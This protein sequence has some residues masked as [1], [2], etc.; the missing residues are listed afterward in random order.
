MFCWNIQPTQGRESI[1]MLEKVRDIFEFFDLDMDG[2]LTLNDI[3]SITPLIDINSSSKTKLLFDPPCD[4]IKFLAKIQSSPQHIANNILDKLQSYIHLKIQ[5]VFDTFSDGAMIMNKTQIKTMYQFAY[6]KESDWRTT[7][8]EQQCTV[9]SFI[10]NWSTLGI[11]EQHG[12][13]NETQRRI[14]E[15]LQRIFTFFDKNS[16]NELDEEQIK[17]ILEL[18]SIDRSDPYF[19]LFD[20]SELSFDAFLSKFTLIH[21]SLTSDVLPRLENHIKEQV[22]WLYFYIFCC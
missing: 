18:L 11:Y 21:R 5:D 22:E 9:D 10:E 3:E 8:H 15:R 2:T 19:P 16:D 20:A 1:E 13:F 12:I 4:F 6:K 7:F 17:L 14:A